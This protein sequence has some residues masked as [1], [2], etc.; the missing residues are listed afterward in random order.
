MHRAILHSRP[1]ELAILKSLGDQAHAAAIPED[2]FDAVG[3]LGPEH[4]NCAG[5]RIGT[6]LGFHQCGQS[7]CAFAE[8][9]GLGGDHDFH[10]TR[11][12]NHDDAFIAWMT[13]AMVALSVPDAILSSAPS[14]SNSMATASGVLLA[15]VFR[16]LKGTSAGLSITA[17][18]NIGVDVCPDGFRDCRRQ[19]NN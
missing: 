4:I 3:S 16:R 1:M 5:E 8:V 11:R 17:G 12:A 7:L 6:H 9:D 10:R 15:I 14:I 19:V 2:Q 18:T 13:A